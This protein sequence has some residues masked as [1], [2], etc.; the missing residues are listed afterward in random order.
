[1]RRKW[2]KVP[3]IWGE[4]L[5]D[6][7]SAMPFMVTHSTP[8]LRGRKS[9]LAQFFYFIFEFLQLFLVLCLLVDTRYCSLEASEGALI[10]LLLDLSLL[11]NNK[12][13]GR[14]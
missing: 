7:D 14:A 4:T 2:K 5:R 3:T 8:G 9:Y 10:F 11:N 12:Q 6:Y 13:L 1:M